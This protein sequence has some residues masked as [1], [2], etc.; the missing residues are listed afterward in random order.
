M[1][2]IIP[3]TRKKHDYD[4]HGALYDCVLTG[5][6]TTI[7]IKPWDKSTSEEKTNLNNG[8]LLCPNHDKLFDKGF[9]SFDSNGK[10]LVSEDLSDV[11]RTFMNVNPDFTLEMND[12]MKEFMEYHR[13]NIFK[14]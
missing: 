3:F 13:D 10:I 8:L 5:T 14:K 1:K 2:W 4:L 6:G 7:H 12:E 9:I 11:D